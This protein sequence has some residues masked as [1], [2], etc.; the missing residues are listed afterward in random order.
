MEQSGND[1]SDEANKEQPRRDEHNAQKEY[2]IVAL[3]IGHA[4]QEL[5]D[6]ATQLELATPQSIARLSA[7]DA[8][9]ESLSDRTQQQDA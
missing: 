9:T 6:N 7:V 5:T 2:N 4:P 1:K 3:G 8:Q